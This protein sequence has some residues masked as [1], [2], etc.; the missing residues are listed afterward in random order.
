MA[1]QS[2]GL[3]MS[4]TPEPKIVKVIS[5][6]IEVEDF[7]VK[8]SIIIIYCYISPCPALQEEIY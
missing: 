3:Y 1:H 2:P 7:N 8:L 4:H 6:T 5:D